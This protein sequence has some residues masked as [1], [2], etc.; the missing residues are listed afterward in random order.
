MMYIEKS[1]RE[2]LAHDVIAWIKS[3]TTN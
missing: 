2:K 3:A 1:S